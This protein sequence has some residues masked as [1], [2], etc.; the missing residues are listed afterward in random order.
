MTVFPHLWMQRFF[1]PSEFESLV[2]VI[3]VKHS[4]SYVM[5]ENWNAQWESSFEPVI[6]PGKVAVRAS[7]HAP[8]S[9]VQHEIII[10]PK[11]S[12]G[13]GHHATTWLMMEEMLTRDFTG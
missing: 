13:T 5:E 2:S 11:M 1:D 8:V 6:I 4:F 3:P 12:F 7:F 10:T 9:G